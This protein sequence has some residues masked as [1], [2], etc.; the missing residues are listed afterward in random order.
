M[1]E[2]VNEISSPLLESVVYVCFRVI[3]VADFLLGLWTSYLYTIE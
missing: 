2:W 1:A 3:I